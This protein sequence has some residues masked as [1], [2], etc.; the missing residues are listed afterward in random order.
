MKI[1]YHAQ[2]AGAGNS[3]ARVFPSG[4]CVQT[5][6]GGASRVQLYRAIGGT[7]FYFNKAEPAKGFEQVVWVLSTV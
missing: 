2:S 5:V 7:E 3:L 1:E 6:V 4:G